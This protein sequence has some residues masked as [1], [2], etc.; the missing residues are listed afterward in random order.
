MLTTRSIS[1]RTLVSRS[2]VLRWPRKYLLTDDVRRELAPELGNLDVLLLEDELARLVADAGGPGLPADLVVGMDARPGPAA[3][4]GQALGL[5]PVGVLA[6]E[7][8]PVRPEVA[9]VVLVPGGLASGL[10]HDLDF[11]GSLGVL[12]SVVSL[13]GGSGHRSSLL[14]IVGRCSALTRRPRRRVRWGRWRRARDGCAGRLF[15]SRYGSPRRDPRWDP[16][17]VEVGRAM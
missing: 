12:G 11:L 1:W 13:D 16:W 7:A 17:A 15:G 10:G 9:G 4:E 14:R 2:G 8:D 5:R 6:V 3:L